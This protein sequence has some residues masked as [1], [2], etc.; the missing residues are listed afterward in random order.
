M[1]TQVDFSPNPHINYEPSS[2]G[3]LKEAAPAGK[4]HTPF[5]QG[6]LV[7]EAIERK[8]DFKQA[9][10]RYRSFEEWE[11]EELINN[12]GAG[13]SGCRKDIQDRMIEMFTQCDP[14]YGKRVRESMAK[15]MEMVKGMP[16][17]APVA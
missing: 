5:V 1:T 9:G 8:N 11:R 12:L 3:G 2:L 10:E 16:E 4:H 15:H 17:P 13:L 7:R 14:D 6:N